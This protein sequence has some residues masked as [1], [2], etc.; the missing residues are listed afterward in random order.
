[1]LK[2]SPLYID[3]LNTSLLLS[4]S[5]CRWINNTAVNVLPVA[6]A[7]ILVGF[8]KNEKLKEIFKY[9]AT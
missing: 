8:I 2:S 9:I 5:L 7:C 4:Y 3:R 6:L 1:M